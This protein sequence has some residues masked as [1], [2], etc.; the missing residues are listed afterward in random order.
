VGPALGNRVAGTL[1]ISS[2]NTGP[3]RTVPLCHKADYEHWA[4][5]EPKTPRS[6]YYPVLLDP[7]TID[8]IAGIL[9][10]DKHEPT[11]ILAYRATG[12]LPKAV[13][14]LRDL[15]RSQQLPPGARDVLAQTDPD[16]AGTDPWRARLAAL[17]LT[18]HLTDVSI[19]EIITAA[20]SPPR[21]G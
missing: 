6:P 17:R 16:H 2:E 7:L 8:E 4:G 12:G 14:L 19:E 21:P 18:R 15:L 11:C 3:A 13:C 5:Q 1:A 20:P 10:I 9:E